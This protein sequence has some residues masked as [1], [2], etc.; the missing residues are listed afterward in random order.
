[1]SQSSRPTPPT[2]TTTQIES[3][4]AELTRHGLPITGT[5]ILRGE[6][7]TR[8]LAPAERRGIRW[9]DD[10]VNNEGQGKKSSKVCCIY[11]KP[12][13]VGESSSES[14]SSDSDSPGSDSEVD[15]GEAGV[16]KGRSRGCRSH[17]DNSHDHDNC[18]N[19][20]PSNT[21]SGLKRPERKPK[22]NAYERV[23]NYNKK[24]EDVKK[25]N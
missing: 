12:R 14:D 7:S 5:L 19:D 20:G 23:P 6:P 9:A 3:P 17:N 4:Q 15:S 24:G 25:E 16:A 10:V 22:R 2:T 13:A 1:M 8:E 11:H 18:H 21:D